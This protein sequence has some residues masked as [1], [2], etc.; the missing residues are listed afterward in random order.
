MATFSTSAPASARRILV[1]GDSGSGKTGAL[2]SLV[3]AG[4]NLRI[5]DLDNNLSILGSLI[6]EDPAAAKLATQVD[7]A[8][9]TDTVTYLNG[10]PVLKGGAKAWPTILKML[11][12]WKTE[13]G[14]FGPLTSW[15]SRDVLVIDTMTFLSTYAF[16][17]VL[18]MNKRFGARPYQSDF[19]EAQKLVEMLL[20]ML[21]D[22]SIPC[23]VVVNSHITRIGAD[24][25][26]TMTD[27]EVRKA[28][29]ETPTKGFPMSVG[30]ALSPKIPTYFD[31]LVY[32]KQIGRRQVLSLTRDDAL[33]ATK[34]PNPKQA[35][36]FDLATGLAQILQS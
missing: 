28:R 6:R 14:E 2:F 18:S 12:N 9:I 34:T 19:G 35:K 31:T 5:L 15:T 29:A 32:A 7:Y 33:I 1:I 20:G 13:T 8:T 11:M 25:D 10:A 16:N 23:H 21:N 30:R 17:H 22:S 4:Y 27:E 24:V 36:D 3:K 26:D